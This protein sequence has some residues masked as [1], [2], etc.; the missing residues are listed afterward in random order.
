M[1]Q[2]TKLYRK[3]VDI[4]APAHPKKAVEMKEKKTKS[5]YTSNSTKLPIGW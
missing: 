2:E 4:L 3:N 1:K 5:N